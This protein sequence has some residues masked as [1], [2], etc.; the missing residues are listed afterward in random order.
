MEMVEA[1]EYGQAPKFYDYSEKNVFEKPKSPSIKGK[2]TDKQKLETSLKWKST[3][4][5]REYVIL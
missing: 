4:A 2:T 3:P 5:S 1:D